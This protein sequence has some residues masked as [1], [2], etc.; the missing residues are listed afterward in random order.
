[1]G[2]RKETDV[3]LKGIEM[4]QSHQAQKR[5]SKIKQDVSVFFGVNQDNV[6]ILA[7]KDFYQ[8]NGLYTIWLKL[9]HITQ[10]QLELITRYASRY[11]QGLR[12]ADR[13]ADVYLMTDIKLK[14][15][16]RF[17]KRWNNLF[18]LVA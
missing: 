8:N 12:Q 7:P 5:A 4:T 1:M 15:F 6:R 11:G 16:L 2:N 13:F 17:I 9:P 14:H 10:D 18:N 3:K